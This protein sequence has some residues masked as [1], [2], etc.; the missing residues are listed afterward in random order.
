[1]SRY[2]TDRRTS[3]EEE[4]VTV[5]PYRGRTRPQLAVRGKK[6]DRDEHGRP[7]CRRG[8][9]VE[10]ANEVQCERGKGA[11]KTCAN[12]LAWAR[13]HNLFVDDLQVIEHMRKT[14]DRLMGSGVDTPPSGG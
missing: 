12:A 4:T 14:Y 5:L 1:V 6:R 3:Y 10:D 7:I 2:A 13:R 9:V 11:C 8:H